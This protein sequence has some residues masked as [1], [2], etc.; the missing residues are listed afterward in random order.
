MMFSRILTAATVAALATV[1]AVAQEGGGLAR[2]DTNG[3]GMI[4]KAE[5]TARASARFDA[6]DKNKDGFLTADERA[7]PGARLL[8]RADANG[9]AKISRAEYLALADKSFARIDANGD[10]QLSKSERETWTQ[11]ARKFAGRHRADPADAIA[12]APT[13]SPNPGH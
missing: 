2:A 10:G 1:A 13:S 5:A 12:P 7:G 3:D 8:D 9:D 4:S 6:M 11:R